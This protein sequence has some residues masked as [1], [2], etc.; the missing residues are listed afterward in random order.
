METTSILTALFTLS[1]LAFLPLTAAGSLGP[2]KE[3]RQQR[4]S[5]AKE[6]LGPQYAESDAKATEKERKVGPFIQALVKKLVPK[7]DRKQ[8]ARISRAILAESEKYNFD[9]M[10]LVALIQNESGFHVHQIGGVGEI[11][12]MQIRPDTAE[13]IAKKY[14]IRYHGDKSLHDPAENIRIGM[15]FLSMLR[16]QFKKES[17]LY[18]SAYNMGARKVRAL[19]EE[20]T[21][22]TIY[23]GNVMRR[24]VALYS[25]L[26]VKGDLDTRT[27][28][29]FLKLRKATG[30]RKVA[31]EEM[32][33]GD[34][35]AEAIAQGRGPASVWDDIDGTAADSS[36]ATVAV[37]VDLPKAV[38][39]EDAIES[40][41]A[42]LLFQ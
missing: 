33:M 2:V 34:A 17:Q 23:V 36:T 39:N 28:Q 42:S 14:G 37:G 4:I 22:P 25:G 32:L 26:R 41:L 35:E 15:A 8:A 6:L 20:A 27:R 7:K 3:N 24:Y 40:G 16:K 10:F 21:T 18:V 29:A 38:L 9:P 11:G 5:H 30:S 12:L 19:V 1:A 13:W 31:G